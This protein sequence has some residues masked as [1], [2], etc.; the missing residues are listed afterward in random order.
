MLVLQKELQSSPPHQWPGSQSG[1]C[2]KL[3][4]FK[5]ISVTITITHINT[6]KIKS[7]QDVAIKHVVSS[8]L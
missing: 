3:Y 8:L 7:S 4:C 5:P 2:D 6:H 1:E